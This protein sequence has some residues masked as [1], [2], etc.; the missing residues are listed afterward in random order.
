MTDAMQ[1]LSTKGFFILGN[2]TNTESQQ[3]PAP[4]P[5]ST[6]SPSEPPSSSSEE[7]LVFS[8]LV[9]VKLYAN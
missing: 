1:H 2:P 6:E 3:T 5:S 9:S 7:L 8:A 4:P